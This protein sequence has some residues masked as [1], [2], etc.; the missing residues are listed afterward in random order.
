MSHCLFE[1]GTSVAQINLE[2]SPGEWRAKVGWQRPS[3]DQSLLAPVP[4]S[5][6][7]LNVPPHQT[8]HMMQLLSA[9]SSN[10]RSFCSDL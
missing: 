10:A 3:A 9:G 5:H 7:G 6:V 8:A 2:K 1:G 4:P